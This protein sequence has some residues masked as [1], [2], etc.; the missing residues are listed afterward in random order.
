MPIWL[1]DAVKKS[2]GRKRR[3][4]RSVVAAQDG[5]IRIGTGLRVTRVFQLAMAISMTKWHMVRESTRQNHASKQT[6]WDQPA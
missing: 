2:G 1:P 5:L 3:G 6:L 4:T